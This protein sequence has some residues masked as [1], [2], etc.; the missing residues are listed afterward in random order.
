VI[1]SFVS[2]LWK[3]STDLA[4]Y[5]TPEWRDAI[6]KSGG[7]L[8]VPALYT[9]PRGVGDVRR[10][11]DEPAG[12]S[13]EAFK[14]HVLDEQQP[15]R[16]V[17]GYEE[18]LLATAFPHHFASRVIARAVTDWSIE[19]WLSRDPRLYGLALVATTLPEE[20]AADIRRV[21]NNDRIVGVQ[22]GTNLLGSSYGHRIYHPIYE[23]AAELDLP[24]VIHPFADVAVTTPTPPT[25]GGLPGSFTEYRAFSAHTAM[26]HICSMIIQGVFDLYPGLRVLLV[27]TGASWLPAVLWRLDWMYKRYPSDAPWIRQLPSQYFGQSVRVASYRLER[28]KDPARL[29]RILETMPWFESTLLYASGYPSAGSE[30]GPE[31]VLE[32]LPEAW[33]DGVREDNALSF[34]R[35]P[36]RPRTVVGPPALVRELMTS[37]TIDR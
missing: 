10:L 16:V 13:Y 5:F 32:R 35:W 27:G 21:G 8:R 4:P 28:P 1:D 17:L 12:T 34:F 22:L 14:A 29:G 33:H 2:H 36:D 30:R 24:I 7:S 18:G 31:S 25:A 9:S 6:A 19:E 20:A 3:S 15:D 37:T 26:S 11:N 23:A